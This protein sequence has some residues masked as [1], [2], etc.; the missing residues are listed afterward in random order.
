MGFFGGWLE[1]RVV[2]RALHALRAL[3]FG[4]LALTTALANERCLDSTFLKKTVNVVSEIAKSEA[5]LL[6]IVLG[7][8]A[9]SVAMTSGRLELGALKSGDFFYFSKRSAVN[10][11]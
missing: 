8:I 9:Q 11:G 7:A 2:L 4:V 6:E 3:Q 5:T 10:R 1:G